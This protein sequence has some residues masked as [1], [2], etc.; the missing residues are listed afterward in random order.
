MS[1]QNSTFFQNGSAKDQSVDRPESPSLQFSF[2]MYRCSYE[3]SIRSF[4]GSQVSASICSGLSALIVFNNRSYIIEHL[5][6]DKHGRHFL[7]RPED[8]RPALKHCRVRNTPLEF[9]LTDHLLHSQ[10]VKRNLQL[11]PRHLEL[12]LVSDNRLYQHLASDRGAVVRRLINIANTMDLYYKPFNIRIALI[13]VEVWTAD[14][15]KVD[16]DAKETM[17]RFLEWR[18]VNLLP[19]MYNDNAHLI[20]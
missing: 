7:Y 17:N 18:R 6:G 10:R 5:A 1:G 13:G 14:Q 4:P 11:E 2:G 3:G 8:L 9:S 20:T 19:R 12:V 15:I 16:N